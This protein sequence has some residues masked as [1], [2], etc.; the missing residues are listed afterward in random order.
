MKKNL[1]KRMISV[2][3]ATVICSLLWLPASAEV[4]PRLSH[5]NR[6]EIPVIGQ[7]VG[8]T[9]L[10][11]AACGASVAN[12]LK[13]TNETAVSFGAKCRSDYATATVY[14]DTLYSYLLSTK[15][16]LSATLASHTVL[17]STTIISQIDARKPIIALID[18]SDSSHVSGVLH[19]VVIQGYNYNDVYGPDSM[20]VH[21]MD[22]A[23]NGV[24]TTISYTQLTQNWTINSYIYNISA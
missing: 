1:I 8:N 11:W 2:I 19:F 15:F 16:N 10:C 18:M 12:Y 13:G 20:T 9:N 24:S 5:Y 6:I 21:Y 4:Q 3:L 7:G 23:N 17:P 22:P 14:A